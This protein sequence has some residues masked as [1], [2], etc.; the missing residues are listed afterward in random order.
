M[1]D[2]ASGEIYRELELPVIPHEIQVATGTASGEYEV[3]PGADEHEDVDGAESSDGGGEEHDHE[4]G[5]HEED[6]H[7]GHDH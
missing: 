1:V 4:G 6:D 2:V 3:A 7:E 5:D